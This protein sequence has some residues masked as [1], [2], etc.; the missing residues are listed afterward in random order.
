I[1]PISPDGVVPAF[2]IACTGTN[3]TAILIDDTE[4]IYNYVYGTYYGG[5][6]GGY[7]RR[8]CIDGVVSFDSFDLN[9]YLNS[10]AGPY[11]QWLSYFHTHFMV[12]VKDSTGVYAPDAPIYRWLVGLTDYSTNKG[13]LVL[14]P[15][16]DR[17]P[18]LGTS[19]SFDFD[20]TVWKMTPPPK[21]VCDPNCFSNVL[22][23]PGLEAS[24][25]YMDRSGGGKDQ[26]WE[27]NGNSDI[28]DLY[29]NT[30]GTSKNLGI[31]TKDIIKETNTPIPTGVLGQNIYKSFSEMMD[32]LVSSGKITEW[33]AFPYDW[34]RGVDDIITNPQKIDGQSTM[35]LEAMLTVLEKSSKNGKVTIVAH[36]NGGLVAKAFLKKLQDDKTAGRNNLI[37]NVDVLILVAVPQIG[38]ASAV[39]ALLHGYDQRIFYG[40]FMDEQ[41][42]RE[43]GRNM[44]G[45]YGLLP[46]QEYINHVDIAP[47]SFSDN[48]TSSGI[49][50]PYAQR[51]GTITD[52]YTKFTEFL[53]GAE[54]R[55]SPTMTQTSL[56]IKLSNSLLSQAS[57][58]HQTIDAWTPPTNM[59]V[60][61]VAGWG[62]DT[63]AG[64]EYY[65]KYVCGVPVQGKTSCQYVLD[66]KPIFT[67]DGDKTVVVP[68]AQYMGF[69]GIGERYWIDMVG[70]KNDHKNI[71]EIKQLGDMVNSVLMKKDIVFDNILINTRPQDT[72]NRLRVSIHSPVTIDAYDTLGNHTGKTCL[73]TS[74]FC[75]AEENIPN[76]SY[77][78]FGEGKYINLPEEGVQKISVQGTGIGTFTFESEKVL[79]DNT[80]VTSVFQD[81]PVTPQTKADITLNPTTKNPQMLLDVDG[82]GTTDFT[83]TPKNEFDPVLYLKVLRK[84]VEGLDMKPVPKFLLTAKIDMTILLIQK[85]KISRAKLSATQFKSIMELRIKLPDPKRPRL[86]IITKEDAQLLLDMINNLLNKLN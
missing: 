35:T 71:L 86:N 14:S 72:K 85:G 18:T 7:M 64:M 82:N 19:E 80:V 60:I 74:D 76:S 34:R 47:V 50:T 63:V 57:T 31:Y 16:D 51:Y 33:Q 40:W 28:E 52:T 12:V 20:G 68:S 29:L 41:H 48:P 44:P 55:V 81:I 3:A 15:D 42:A 77:L 37:D 79:P 83:V 22:F 1:A 69:K 84:T 26:L 73:P 6:V 9:D 53:T 39:S 23:I 54:G 66:E 24:R 38:T 11:P 4:P 62:L 30:D 10:M 65:P 17:Y 61:E 32:G 43:L 78:E 2:S 49:V 21:P 46:S 25:L 67:A 36:S 70:L 56:P 8:P 58:L 5:S 45:G 75:Y 13:N 59:R 27:P